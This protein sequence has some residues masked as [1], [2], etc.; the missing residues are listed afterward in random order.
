MTST[1]DNKICCI[2]IPI[3]FIVNIVIEAFCPH[4]YAVFVPYIIT[5]I[6]LIWYTLSLI[7]AV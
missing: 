5:F 4:W 6:A 1:L 3:G 2:I 7:P